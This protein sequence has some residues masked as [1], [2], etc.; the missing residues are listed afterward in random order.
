MTEPAMVFK[1][2]SVPA[3][4]AAPMTE[5]NTLTGVFMHGGSLIF[6]WGTRATT[7]ARVKAAKD[8]TDFM[9]FTREEANNKTPISLNRNFISIVG[10]ELPV[11]DMLEATEQAQKLED[12]VMEQIKGKLN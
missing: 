2:P 8:F 3:P 6:V 10:A 1:F 12:Q 7:L 5:D 11:S 9:S 4:E